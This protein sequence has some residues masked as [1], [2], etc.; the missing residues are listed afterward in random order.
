MWTLL[1][2]CSIV[3][4]TL[5]SGLYSAAC[6]AAQ[7]RSLAK[8]FRACSC[9]LLDLSCFWSHCIFSLSYRVVLLPFLLVAMHLYTRLRSSRFTSPRCRSSSQSRRINNLCLRNVWRAVSY[10]PSSLRSFCLLSFL[11]LVSS[12]MPGC[13]ICDV[14]FFRRSLHMSCICRPR[15]TCT[16]AAFVAPDLLSL[17]GS[18]FCCAN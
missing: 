3:R 7:C 10:S 2:S 9:F 11:M 13:I 12:G 5:C 15:F 17:P 4:S 18:C 14:W 16:W 8:S 1:L 6:R